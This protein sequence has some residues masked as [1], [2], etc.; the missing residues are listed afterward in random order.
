MHHCGH[1]CNSCIVRTILVVVKALLEDFNHVLI[2]VMCECVLYVVI[3]DVF[4]D[5][6]TANVFPAI[7]RSLNAQYN[8]SYDRCLSKVPV[9]NSK[10]YQKF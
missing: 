2:D 4:T 3:P 9:Q 8:L 5:I 7:F 1:V 6:F 10:M